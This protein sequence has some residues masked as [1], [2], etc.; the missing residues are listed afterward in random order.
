MPCRE[1]YSMPVHITFLV[2]KTSVA[3]ITFKTVTKI[4][5]LAA[6]VSQIQRKGQHC[7]DHLAIGHA[8]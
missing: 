5:L 4:S 7:E 3:I 2:E 8:E 1:S 6:A